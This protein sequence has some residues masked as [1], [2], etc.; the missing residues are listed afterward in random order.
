MLPLRE[1]M[2]LALLHALAGTI[3]G[4]SCGHA[5]MLISNVKTSLKLKQKH[6]SLAYRVYRMLIM[7][8][9]WSP[10]ALWLLKQSSGETRG[11]RASGSYM[12]ILKPSKK[13]VY[14]FKL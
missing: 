1:I 4:G 7:L 5:M 11:S 13:V 10:I 14:G 6:V 2:V 9:F 12:M 8:L 3:L